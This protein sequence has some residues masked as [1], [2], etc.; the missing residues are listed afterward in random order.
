MPVIFALC[1]ALSVMLPQAAKADLD[2]SDR[3]AVTALIEEFIRNNP[4]AVRD[5][6][7]ALAAREETARQQAGLAKV[8]D[9]RGDPTMGNPNGAITLYEFSDYNCGYCKRVFEPIQQMLRN[10]KDVRLVIKEFPI[11]SQSS[12]VAAKAAIAA[13]MQGKFSDFHVAMMTYR[14]QI[15]NDVVMRIAG[16]V[17]LDNAQLQIDMESPATAAIIQ[18]TRDAA[19]ALGING[20]PGLVIGDKV[21]PGAIGLEELT[22]LIADERANQS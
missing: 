7:L 16:Q 11:L 1:L 8:R 10:N 22:Q 5:S 6:L 19:T 12:L 21:I 4:Q 18:R 3:A 9:D 14:G 17:G 13:E 2:A 15:T 20:T